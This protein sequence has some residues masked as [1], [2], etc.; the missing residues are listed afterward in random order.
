MKRFIRLYPPILLTLVFQGVLLLWSARASEET[1]PRIISLLSFTVSLL[2]FITGLLPAIL[3]PQES[4]TIVACFAISFAFLLL[5]PID[6]IDISFAQPGKPLYQ[7]IPPLLLSRFINGSI[8]LPMAIHM[9]ARFPRNNGMPSRLIAGGYIF[10]ILLAGAFLLATSPWPRLIGLMFLFAW[11]AGVIVFFFANLLRAARDTEN[12]QDAQRARIVFFSIA[13]AEIPLLLRPF[14]IALG[15][16]PL[17]YNVI[18]LFQL[19]VP[20]GIAY[21]VLRHDLFGIDRVL[22]RTLAYGTV[23]L[24]LLTLYLALTTGIT[25]LLLIRLRRG[26]WL[27]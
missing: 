7:F 18:L 22:R 19:F 24:L 14:S 1:I 5:V 21:A 15:L 26:H 3:R 8:L 20:L 11:F 13:F 27:H 12:M 23:S 4:H 6:S 2:I 17:P 16:T 9:S 10:S 25:A